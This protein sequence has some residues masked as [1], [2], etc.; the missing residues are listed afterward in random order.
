MKV[1][2]LHLEKYEK[3][4]RSWLDKELWRLFS[5]WIR[6]KDA[7]EN[8]IVRCATCNG[9]RHWRY[10]DAGHFMSRR[11]MSTKFHELNVHPQC[12]QCN[13]PGAG[14]QFKMGQYIDEKFGPGTAD[15]IKDLSRQTVHWDRF[16]FIYNIESYKKKLRD[17]QFEIK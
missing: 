6:Q 11:H 1:E 13:G 8:G 5:L 9:F 10:L 12:K 17:H 15:K 4:S 16:D 2:D 7:D 14:E 3:R